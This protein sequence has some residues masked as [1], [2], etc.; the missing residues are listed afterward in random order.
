MHLV[1]SDMYAGK[2]SA[3]LVLSF[4]AESKRCKKFAVSISLQ[5]K[6]IRISLESLGLEYIPEVPANR[7]EVGQNHDARKACSAILSVFK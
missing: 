6:G 1:F 2:R 7:A 5:T 4:S 3:R